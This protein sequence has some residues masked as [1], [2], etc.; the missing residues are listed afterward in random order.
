MKTPFVK[1]IS[2]EI[3]RSNAAADDRRRAGQR[4]ERHRRDVRELVGEPE[5]AGRWISVRDQQADRE[6]QRRSAKL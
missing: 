5:V 2:G 3:E 4:G 6:Q 1:K